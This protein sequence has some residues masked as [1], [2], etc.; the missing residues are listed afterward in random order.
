M[1]GDGYSGEDGRGEQWSI[2]SSLLTELP[3]VNPR[4]ASVE[5]VWDWYRFV[6]ALR[7]G[8]KKSPADLL[9]FDFRKGGNQGRTTKSVWTLVEWPSITRT[10]Y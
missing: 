7:F 10:K 6:L 2:S 8:A 4:Q 5:S 9:G 3:N 1:I